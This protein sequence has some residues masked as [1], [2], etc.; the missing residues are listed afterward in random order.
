MDRATCVCHPWSILTKQSGQ[1]SENLAENFCL[2]FPPE[3][4]DSIVLPM[5]YEGCVVLSV[6]CV[7]LDR[8]C[9]TMALRTLQDRM[10][11]M[12]PH[13][14]VSFRESSSILN[15]APNKNAKGITST[16]RFSREH[17]FW[18]DCCFGCWRR[19]F[20]CI[21]HSKGTKSGKCTL[22]LNF[23]FIAETNGCLQLKCYMYLC[24]WRVMAYTS[25]RKSDWG[26]FP[27]PSLCFDCKQNTTE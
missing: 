4:L 24:R 3:I 16:I 18:T 20:W 7:L 21:W 13:W 11:Q 23:F 15:L 14:L 12:C 6:S 19:S 17:N 5:V 8:T 25:W 1:N 26:L 10:C 22:V 27:P 2:T 9:W